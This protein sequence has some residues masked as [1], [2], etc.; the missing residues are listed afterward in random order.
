MFCALPDYNIDFKSLN[1]LAVSTCINDF[2]SAGVKKFKNQTPI[3][4]FRA[5]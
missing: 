3:Q 4:D 5:N 2:V 1:P